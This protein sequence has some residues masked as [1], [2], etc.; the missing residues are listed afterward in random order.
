MVVRDE[1]LLELPERQAGANELPG[2][3]IATVDHVNLAAGDYRLRT[4]KTI[5]PHPGAARRAEEDEAGSVTFGG[6]SQLPQRECRGEQAC[7]GRASV[8][9]HRPN[10]RVHVSARR[11]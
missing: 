5:A 2:N 4:R 9:F 7:E 6:G 1:N 11:G 10:L 3:A 8:Q